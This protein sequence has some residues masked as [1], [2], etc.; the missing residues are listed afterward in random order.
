MRLINFNHMKVRIL[1]HQQ[2]SWN[3]PKF[4]SSSTSS[5]KNHYLKV[6]VIANAIL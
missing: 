5:V 6:K 2:F 4:T 3:F 1:G